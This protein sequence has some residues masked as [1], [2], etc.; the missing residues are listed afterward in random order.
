VI[1]I[2]VQGSGFRV[3]GLGFQNLLIPESQNSSIP[4]FF[5]FLIIGG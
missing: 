2:R 5:L 4:E 3:Q 1:K